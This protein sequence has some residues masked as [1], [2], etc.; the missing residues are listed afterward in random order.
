MR[1]GKGLL[2]VLLGCASIKA[3]DG[4]PPD[5]QPPSL[6]SL[7]FHRKGPQLQ[8]RLRWGEFLGPGSQLTPPGLWT[9]PPYPTRATL[10]GK[11]LRIQID[12]L[13]AEACLT[14]WGGPGLK[15]F[16]EGNPLPPTPLWT[17]CP[18]A[19]TLHLQY[20]LSP[21]PS[22]QNPV[23]AT[24]CHADTCYRFLAWAGS[25][26]PTL[27]PPGTYH[28]WAWEDTDQNGEWAAPEPLWLPDSFV[29]VLSGVAAD[30]GGPPPWTRWQWDTTGPSLPRPALRDSQWGLFTFAE[31]VHLIEGPGYALSE[32][33]LCLA[34]GGAFLLADSAGNLRRDT[35]YSE[36]DTQALRFVAFWPA[37]AN[38]ASPQLYLT[39]S[40]PLPPKDTFWTAPD[41]FAIASAYLRGDEVYLD[42]LPTRQ[43]V[44]FVLSAEGG[45]TLRLLLP[46]QKVRVTLPV[47][48]VGGIRQ[49]RLY[50]PVL[51]GRPIRAQAL[52]GATVWLPPGTYALIGLGGSS[53]FWQPIEVRGGRP[54][55]RWPA[56]RRLTLQ[57]PPLSPP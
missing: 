32:Y 55:L 8:I 6:R 19:E 9:N 57:V 16:T 43:E 56:L 3:P 48:S 23:W 34:R 49:W 25:L 46:G 41:T 30:S 1:G 10:H 36:T 20:T 37:Q 47:D 52:A 5:T 50:G 18:P 27:L 53:P 39:L 51:L 13:P 54:L 45:D 28:A 7:S 2:V 12:S 17:N 11:I 35:F 24:F 29:R 21:P 33:G 15:D 42:P 14:L 4:G 44:P 38:L 26:S 22:T 40:K 31:P